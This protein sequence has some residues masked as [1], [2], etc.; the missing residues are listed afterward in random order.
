MRFCG[1]AEDRIDADVD[2]SFGSVQSRLVSTAAMCK[3]S[4]CI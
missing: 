1:I 4:S 3:K 2:V